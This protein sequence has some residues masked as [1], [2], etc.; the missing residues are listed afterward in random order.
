MILDSRNEFCNATS[1]N[2]GAAGTYLLGDQIDLGAGDKPIGAQDELYLV[3]VVQTTAT[4]GGS[5]T[6]QLKLSSD[7]SASI[8]TNGTATDHFVSRVFPVASL[9]AGTT[10]FATKLPM[11]FDYERYLGI[12]QVTGTAAFTAGKIDVFLTPDPAR[13]AAYDSPSHL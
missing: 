2:T 8:A 10:L 7:D 12:L 9:V 1:L 6:L 3:A 4:S 5:A 11:G 13:W